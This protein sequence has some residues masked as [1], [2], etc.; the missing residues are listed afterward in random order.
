LTGHK[1]KQPN[2]TATNEVATE[3]GLLARALQK[4]AELVSS[5]RKIASVPRKIASVAAPTDVVATVPA[6]VAANSPNINEVIVHHAVEDEANS[7]DE[8]FRVCLRE[9]IHDI[10][11]GK[12]TYPLSRESW[13]E[14]ERNAVID[15][16]ASINRDLKSGLITKANQ[17]TCESDSSEDYPPGV[18]NSNTQQLKCLSLMETR[19]IEAL[20]YC[21]P[22][23]R[24]FHVDDFDGSDIC[25][26]P[27]GRNVEPWMTKYNL[28]DDEPRCSQN[29]RFRPDAL[30]AHLYNKSNIL[31]EK[32]EIIKTKSLSCIYHYAA[33]MYLR[34]LYAEETSPTK[35]VATELV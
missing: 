16:I 30:M 31:D 26:C 7:C 3:G 20:P 18:S 34:I 1:S 19:F 5:P 6:V 24:G 10:P 28:L 2:Q 17:Y 14:K 29:N 23:N 33:A 9:I 21:P 27:C 32:G 4:V 25:F 12:C 22:L 11:L 15:T 35:V 13:N 8:A